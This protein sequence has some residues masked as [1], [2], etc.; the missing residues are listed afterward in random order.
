MTMMN[1]WGRR[2]AHKNKGKTISAINSQRLRLLFTIVAVYIVLALVIFSSSGQ[3]AFLNQLLFFVLIFVLYVVSYIYL[4]SYD[5]ILLDHI[6][7]ANYR[8]YLE[9]VMQKSYIVGAKKDTYHIKLVQVYFLE[10][11]FNEALDQLKI[12]S[13]SLP[14]LNIQNQFIYFYY[15]FLVQLFNRQKAELES[16]LKAVSSLSLKNKEIE[17]RLKSEVQ[18]LYNIQFEHQTNPYF[19]T[20]E[21]RSRLQ[22]LT[23]RYYQVLNAQV[24]GKQEKVYQLYTELAKENED[25]FFVK[26]ARNYL[27][28]HKDVRK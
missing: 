15:L 17:S 26:E 2:L 25:L 18:A 22:F 16:T 4:I 20:A 8:Q 24:E 11:R 10:G 23:Y 21:Y 19:D 5:Y 6:E 14:R 9:K 13:A 3:P 27:E 12:I 1:Q 28:G 7:I